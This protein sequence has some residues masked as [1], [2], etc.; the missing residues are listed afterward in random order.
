[1]NEKEKNSENKENLEESEKENIL[2]IKD[3]EEEKKTWKY[4]QVE[5]SMGSFE[6]E[7]YYKHA[8][9]TCFNFG[10][11]ANQSYFN[12][13]T[14]HRVIKGIFKLNLIRFYDSSR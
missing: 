14:F 2:K 1:M 11:L 7:L 9:K 5:T 6:L 8:P 12:N 13:T 10:E 3:E 4:V